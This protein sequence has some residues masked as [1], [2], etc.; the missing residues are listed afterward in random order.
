[1]NSRIIIPSGF[2]QGKKHFQKA[3]RAITPVSSIMHKFDRECIT[4][5]HHPVKMSLRQDTGCPCST[6]PSFQQQP[7]D[8]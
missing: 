3:Q 2:W 8:E 4:S 1:M 5:D 7:G 6:S